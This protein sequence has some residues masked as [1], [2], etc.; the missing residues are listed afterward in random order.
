MRNAL[1]RSFRDRHLM[2]PQIH[3]YEQATNFVFTR[4]LFWSFFFPKPCLKIRGAAYVRVFMVD[5][6]PIA[7]LALPVGLVGTFVTSKS[8]IEWI[9]RFLVWKKNILIWLIAYVF[10]KCLCLRKMFFVL[11]RAWDKEKN[12]ESPWG[13]EPE[14]HLWILSH[15]D[16]TVSEAYYEVHMTR[17]QHI[18]T[19][20]SCLLF[21]VFVLRYLAGC[22]HSFVRN[23]LIPSCFACYCLTM[24]FIHISVLKPKTLPAFCADLERFSLFLEMWCFFGI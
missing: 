7:E 24:S 23:F 8:L 22:K 14:T 18:V 21:I 2:S 1:D 10:Q 3:I 15:R 13:I 11:S 6:E 5:G 9:T 19:Y 17:F 4:V 12:S 20:F 16:S